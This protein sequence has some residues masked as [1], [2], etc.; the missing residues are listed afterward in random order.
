MLRAVLAVALAVALAGVTLSALADAR[1]E[2]SARLVEGEL[3]ALEGA[4]VDLAETEEVAARDAA[5]RRTLF[6]TVP[7]RGLAETRVEYVSIGG[8]PD[9]ERV[10]GGERGDVLAYRL[11]GGDVRIRRVPVA[12]RAVG[13]DGTVL[14]AGTPLVVR[15]DA[16]LTL[17]L[18][19]VDGDRAVLV[20]RTS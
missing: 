3:N 10:A 18:V 11:A 1:D 13:P 17:S 12:L 8:V 20:E 14:P 19:E 9:A 6:V 16:R 15:G 7:G 2:R 4:A 5:A